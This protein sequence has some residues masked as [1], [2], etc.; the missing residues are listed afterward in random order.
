MLSL[1]FRRV[2]QATLRFVPELPDKVQQILTSI[3]TWMAGEA[4]LL[5]VYDRP[6]WRE[7]GL[8][9]DG[10]SRNGPLVEIHDASPA[11][12][13]P[14]ALFGFVELPPPGVRKQHSGQMIEMAKRQLGH[15]F[16]ARE[17]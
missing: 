13:G 10:M 15:I 7:A 5:A 3:P 8:S 14:F 6:H 1:Q 4:K 17:C 16:G 9:G 12:A 2:A 11:A